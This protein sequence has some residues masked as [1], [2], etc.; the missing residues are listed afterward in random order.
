[1]I[2]IIRMMINKININNKAIPGS[3]ESICFSIS[4]VNHIDTGRTITIN[5]AID[6]EIN[7][8]FF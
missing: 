8:T 5:I 4:T 2:D 1:M 7:Q 3:I 6:N